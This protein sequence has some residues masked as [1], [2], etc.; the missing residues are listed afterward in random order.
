M[1]GCWFSV[2]CN[3]YADKPVYNNIKDLNGCLFQTGS[4]YLIL[5][6]KNTAQ[7]IPYV[8]TA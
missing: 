5:D 1:H 6:K 7:Y 8:I 3:S 4:Q 2:A